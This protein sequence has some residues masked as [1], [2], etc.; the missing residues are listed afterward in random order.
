MANMLA[1]RA[2]ESSMI[3]QSW[4]TH[5]MLD[6]RLR[7]QESRLAQ[8]YA[9][10]EQEVLARDTRIRQLTA[11]QHELT[12]E[13]QTQAQELAA[14][15]AYVK[16]NK[17]R[18]AEFETAAK[19]GG[20]G[21]AGGTFGQETGMGGANMAAG[22]ASLASVTA[23]A[24]KID[25]LERKLMAEQQ[26]RRFAAERLGHELNALREMLT[27]QLDT[28]RKA[29]LAF[30]D[31]SER[32]R[33]KLVQELTRDCEDRVRRLAC[34]SVKQQTEIVDAIE[35]EKAHRMEGDKQHRLNTTKLQGALNLLKDTLRESLEAVTKRIAAIE[36][37]IQ[38]Q[39]GDVNKQP[40][41]EVSPEEAA[42][43]LAQAQDGSVQQLNITRF[44]QKGHPFNSQQASKMLSPRETLHPRTLD[45]SGQALAAPK[46]KFQPQGSQESKT[47][48]SSSKPST[49]RKS[50]SPRDDYDQD[51]A[52]DQVQEELS[53]P[54]GKEVS[55][56]YRQEMEPSISR[57]YAS[58]E[59]IFEQ[60]LG[61][62]ES[63]NMSRQQKC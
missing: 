59:E 32:G 2:S 14:L 52:E 44:M 54:A 63:R 13:V 58:P 37:G 50:N 43:L 11:K 36:Q 27:H 8:F 35:A 31:A 23:L 49:P 9:S 15:R 38:Q 20:V 30:E 61:M 12:L 34:E 16:E 48:V 39:R 47:A 55:T 19:L 62:E 6:E 46:S 10:L 57:L 56:R 18:L 60:A 29:R 5:A 40:G 26:E 4:A 51:E 42:R 25:D 41:L 17:A 21:L 24:T 1:E 45:S 33:S 53:H 28:E 22:F 7:N 3:Q